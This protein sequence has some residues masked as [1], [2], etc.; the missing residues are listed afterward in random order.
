MGLF[1]RRTTILH[2]LGQLASPKTI[3]PVAIG[4]ALLLRK[5]PR[6]KQIPAA[7]AL[8]IAVTDL[9]KIDVNERRPALFC[10]DE[11]SSFPSGHSAATAALF[12][13]LAHLTKSPIAY[14]AAVLASGA[15]NALRVETRKHWPHDVLAGDAIAIAAVSCTAM[16]PRLLRRSA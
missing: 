6:A 16:A 9:L 5:N 2:R 13:G 11:W 4:L 1:R 3:L 12:L 14:V 15:V 8:A 10:H 7:T